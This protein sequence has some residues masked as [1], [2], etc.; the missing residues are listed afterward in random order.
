[1]NFKRLYQA[2]QPYVKR[3]AFAALALAAWFVIHCAVITASG[4]ADSVSVSDP[5]DAAVILGNQVFLNGTV[6][7][8][9][10]ARLRKALD[11]YNSGAA[12]N[13]IC[14]GGKG[15]GQVWEADVMREWLMDRGVDPEHVIVDYEGKDSYCTARAARKIFDEHGWKTALIV[16]H[17]AHITRCNLAFRRFGFSELRSAHADFT[18]SDFIGYPHEF[19]GY[20]YYLVRFDN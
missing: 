4:F 18:L 8:V 16:T 11:V 1:M 13:L 6:G 5:A 3:F 19:F 2:I 14:S 20:Y 7:D 15:P 12:R 17:A 9:L 10:E